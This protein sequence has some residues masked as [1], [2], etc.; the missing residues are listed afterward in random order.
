MRWRWPF[1]SRWRLVAME[2][3]AADAE[4]TLLILRKGI[5]EDQKR[6]KDLSQQTE[7]LILQLSVAK[8]DLDQANESGTH[9]SSMLYQQAEVID[10]LLNS[11]V[12]A[13]TPVDWKSPSA[14]TGSVWSEMETV[15]PV[16]PSPLLS[17]HVSF[18]L[19]TLV[20][21]REPS[22][23]EEVMTRVRQMFTDQIMKLPSQKRR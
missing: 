5:L 9:T 14:V 8:R 18:P 20:N 10:H 11:K 15:Y 4:E 23:L 12:R 13:V 2:A 7:D 19:N 21:M 6:I 17:F 3:R 16:P 1:V 22:F